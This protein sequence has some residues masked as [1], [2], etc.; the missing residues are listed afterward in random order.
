[1]LRSGDAIAHAAHATALLGSMKTFLTTNRVALLSLPTGIVARPAVLSQVPARAMLALAGGPSADAPTQEAL[2][3]L[4]RRGALL[5]GLGVPLSGGQFVLIECQKLDTAALVRRM[6]EC[7]R[8][9]PKIRIVAVGLPNIDDL[10][11]ALQNG[12]DL[13]G[14]IPDRSSTPP[15]ANN[16]APRM[17]R[18]CQLLNRIIG[19]EDLNQ[20]GK[21]LRTDVGL[22][23][24]L[25]R[26]ANSPL[27]GLSRPT[28]SAEQAVML[29][30]RNGVYRWLSFLLLAGADGR[31]S[32]RALQEVALARARLLEMLAP[33]LGAPPPALFTTGLFSLMEVMLS[34]PLAD[35]LRPLMLPEAATQA[36][37]ENSGPWRSALD[38]AQALERD[39]PE[40]IET[41][42]P[43]FGGL[44]EVSAKA[45][46][47]WNW[48]AEAAAQTRAS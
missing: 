30:G 34:V 33:R 11:A 16:L 42:A 8:A 3:E 24:R 19:E 4:R 26:Y 15:K 48:A 1:M 41:L 17:Q 40:A 9:D 47:A 43:R 20:V 23:Y 14:G 35:A 32:S 27:L 10:E 5:G 31:P 46:E 37:L 39:D 45:Q 7:R 38:L 6:D 21:D 18:L 22:V 12:V 36:L 44:D 25:L 29:L 2:G 28:E 13:A